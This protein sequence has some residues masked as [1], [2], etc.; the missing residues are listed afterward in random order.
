MRVSERYSAVRKNLLKIP[1]G[2]KWRKPEKKPCSKLTPTLPTGPKQINA[3]YTHE[4]VK[5]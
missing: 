4:P 5:R 3:K 2:K 1:V